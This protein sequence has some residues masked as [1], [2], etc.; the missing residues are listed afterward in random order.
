VNQAPVLENVVDTDQLLGLS[1]LEVGYE[2]LRATSRRNRGILELTVGIQE[3]YLVEA[4][5][6]LES[7]AVVLGI[8]ETLGK[9]L[10]KFAALGHK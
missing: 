6:R 7:L 8:H 4:P 3:G 2:V 9:I 10:A 1:C 5:L